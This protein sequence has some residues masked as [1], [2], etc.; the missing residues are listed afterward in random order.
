M[1]RPGTFLHTSAILLDECRE[2]MVKIQRSL[3]KQTE[4]ACETTDMPQ[5]EAWNSRRKGAT[6]LVSFANLRGINEGQQGGGAHHT[7]RSKTERQETT[8]SGRLLH[9]LEKR[10]EGIKLSVKLR[11][12]EGDRIWARQQTCLQR[13]GNRQ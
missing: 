3:R 10:K 12:A 4:E 11:L 8:D 6:I 5:H 13:V 9:M 7:T 1:T 2:K